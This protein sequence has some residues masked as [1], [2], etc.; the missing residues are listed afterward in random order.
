MRGIKNIVLIFVVSIIALIATYLYPQK[1][2]NQDHANATTLTKTIT[3]KD[4]WEDGTYSTSTIDTL[5]EPGSIKLYTGKDGGCSHWL[6]SCDGGNSAYW[7]K[8]LGSNDSK[9]FKFFVPSAD[10]PSDV[11]SATL[12]LYGNHGY[13]SCTNATPADPRYYP[14]GVHKITANWSETAMT[15]PSRDAAYRTDTVDL[16]SYGAFPDCMMGDFNLNTYVAFNLGGGTKAQVLDKWAGAYGFSISATWLDIIDWDLREYPNNPY[17][18]IDFADGSQ[19][20]LYLPEN[21][22]ASQ[23]GSHISAADQIDGGENLSAWTSFVP[24]ETIPANTAITYQFRTSTDASIWGPWTAEADYSGSPIDLSGLSAER[25]LQVKSN[26]STDDLSETPALNAFTV[27]YESEG[28]CDNFD[29]LNISPSS[30]TLES[31]ASTTITAT[32]VDAGGTSFTTISVSYS[33]DCGSINGTGEYT[34]PTTASSTTCTVTATSDCGGIATSTIT[35]NGTDDPPLACNYNGIQDNGETG[36]DCGGGSCDECSPPKSTGICDTFSRLVISP[37]NLTIGTNQPAIINYYGV[38]DSGNIMSELSEFLVVE[39]GTLVGNRYTAPSEPGTYSMAASSV[40]GNA[41]GSINVFAYTPPPASLTCTDGIKNGD[42]TRVDCGGSCPACDEPICIGD[43]CH[44]EGDI[45]WCHG[46]DCNCSDPDHCLPCVGENCVCDPERMVCHCEGDECTCNDPE[47]CEEE[48]KPKKPLPICIG[49]YCT[50]INID[51][52]IIE[53]AGSVSTAALGVTALVASLLLLMQGLANVLTMI[54]PRELWAYLLKGRDKKRAKGLVY[55]STVGIGIPLAKVLLIRRRDQKLIRVATSGS[56]GKFAL[57]TPPGE[58]YYIEVKKEGYE[59][60]S[61]FQAKLQRLNLA[62]ENNYFGE[63]F[64]TD[65]THLLFEQAIPLSPNEDSIRLALSSR[66]L[67]IVTKVFRV[68]NIPLLLFGFM[69][70]TLALA[71]TKSPYNY[72]IFYLYLLIFLYYLVKFFFI[73]GRSFGL[74]INSAKNQGVDLAVVRAISETRGKLVKTTVTNE[75]GRYTL[76]LPKGFYKI[77]ATK[78]ELKQA[79]SLSVR[80]KSNLR[81]RTER[82]RMIE[83]R[84]TPTTT[85]PA[86]ATSLTTNERRNVFYPF[87][88]NKKQ[89]DRYFSDSGEIIERYSGEIKEI[90]KNQSTAEQSD[91]KPDHD[92]PNWKFT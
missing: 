60:L 4:E 77:I 11:T 65:D 67:E 43:D 54:R 69:M 75:K 5:T 78:P 40:C 27:T 8:Y 33:A 57:E 25:Y 42:E 70:S 35:V 31:G 16:N 48:P 22:G 71:A 47:R 79:S 2:D 19:W 64:R 15:T 55:D 32:P 90:G 30:A 7:T 53:V 39:A 83:T 26:L 87:S 89:P 46:P 1:W 76:V 66:T 17:M 63:K 38:D 41:S 80:V 91:E 56:D 3:T 85:T 10:F 62:Y 21:T 20:T 84:Q 37:N 18:V 6:G 49:S 36:I 92:I 58:E 28:L 44:C 82:I 13:W 34:A 59:M 86:M 73:D 29:H 61:G 12:Y 51:P 50:N 23:E 74:V 45:C 88:T 68:L 24:S 81:P 14:Y 72:T 9:Y 52:G